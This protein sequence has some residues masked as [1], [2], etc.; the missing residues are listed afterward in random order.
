MG[1]F[2]YVPDARARMVR[3]DNGFYQWLTERT[4]RDKNVLGKVKKH[5]QEPYFGS[6]EEGTRFVFNEYI[7]SKTPSLTNIYKVPKLKKS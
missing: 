2:I 3:I 6:F 5:T 1:Q 7:N 4:I